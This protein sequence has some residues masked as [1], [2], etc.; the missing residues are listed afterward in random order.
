VIRRRPAIPV[1]ASLAAFAISDAG[2]LS[3]GPLNGTLIL[4]NALWDQVQVEVR[5]GPS[6]SC[7]A[8]AALGVVALGRDQRW[9]VVSDQIVCWRR[10][11]LPGNPTAGWTAWQQA[12][13]APG[14]MQSV[15][16]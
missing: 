12:Q 15:T 8:A 2:V 3:G 4:R 14:A 10:E 6:A 1:I 9:A 13:P 5:V 7:D 11:Q 16:L